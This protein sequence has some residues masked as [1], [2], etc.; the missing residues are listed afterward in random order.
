MNES[1]QDFVDRAKFVFSGPPWPVALWGSIIIAGLA[2]AVGFGPTPTGIADG[3]LLVGGPAVVATVLTPALAR[4]FSGGAVG[5]KRSALLALLCTLVITIFVIGV[6]VIQSIMGTSVLAPVETILI[7]STGILVCR[8]I[9]VV[10]LSGPPLSRAVIPAGIQSG[11]A[12]LAVAL[13]ARPEP[14][15]LGIALVCAVLYAGIPLGFVMLVDTPL[16]RD[17]GIS[18]FEFVH[19]FLEYTADRSNDLESYFTQLGESVEVPVTVLSIRRASGEEKARVISTLAH[20]GPFAGIGGGILPYRL[21]DDGPL[22]F[23]PH[24]LA[25][26]DYDPTSEAGV[27]AVCEAAD[28]AFSSISY[29]EYATPP[30]QREGE[31]TLTG[32]AFGDGALVVSTFAPQ[33]TDDVNHRV[34]QQAIAEVNAAGIENALLADA[35]NCQTTT[36]GGHTA[37]GSDRA[38]LLTSGIQRMATDLAASERGRLRVGVAADPTPWETKEGIGPLGIRALATE[39]RGTTAVYIL[40]DGNNMI[41]GLRDAIRDALD[42]DV[43]EVLTTDSHEVNGLSSEN[44]V[45]TNIDTERFVSLIESVGT[46]AIGDLEPVAAGTATETAELTV[47]G[48]DTVESL[49][50]YG[51]YILPR[52]GAF[53]AVTTVVVTAIAIALFWLV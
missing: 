48:E 15:T 11:V 34:G 17:W 47:F 44:Y 5:T 45:G 1:S 38:Q 23:A 49:T 46:A 52:C 51:D 16:R 4:R 9:V 8:L 43:V 37:P 12:V 13:V 24:G 40:V 27:T 19:Q 29:D 41:V 28:R 25:D 32:Q 30:I 50:A 42:A 26:H 3:L 6:T 33:A 31:P 2:G 36:P 53:V 14:E 39:V 22:T 21:A 7:A 10:S 18:G 35:H 20:P